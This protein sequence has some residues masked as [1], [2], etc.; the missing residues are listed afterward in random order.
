MV[1]R[2]DLGVE[3]P[4]E[5]IPELQKSIISLCNLRAVPVITATQMLESIVNNPSPTR[6]EVTDIAN[7]IFDGT[8]AV[9][10]SEETT[11][12]K[13]PLQCV[14]LL[15]MVALNAEKE[16]KNYS[17]HRNQESDSVELESAMCR[18]AT[19]IAHSIGARAIVTSERVSLRSSPAT[20]Q[21]C[22]YSRCRRTR[23][24]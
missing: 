20:G 15:D 2:G 17:A 7:S 21:A 1:A 5:Q 16:L 24:R 9:M 8:D 13:Y 23:S 18:A 11:V 4:I 6:A 10:L 12:G 3:N 14:R 22:P 19:S